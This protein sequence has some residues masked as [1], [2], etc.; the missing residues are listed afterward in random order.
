MVGPAGQTMRQ[1]L[2]GKRSMLFRLGTAEMTQ[3]VLP[4]ILSMHERSSMNLRTHQ[5][6]GTWNVQGMTAG[7]LEIVTKRM[8]EQHICVLGISK[9]WC[10]NQGRFTT[11]NGYTVIYSGK[12]EGKR[13]LVSSWTGIQ[14]DPSWASTQSATESSL[15]DC[16][17]TL[18]TYQLSRFMHQ[19]PLHLMKRW[20]TFMVSSKMSWIRFQAKIC[21][22]SWE[23]GTQKLARLTSNQGQLKVWIGRRNDRGDGLE[24]F[25]Q[26]ND[27][28]VETPSFSS[29]LQTVDLE[30]RRRK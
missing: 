9:T 3:S 19:H 17:V 10:L 22:S 8:G 23:T 24:E 5:V 6:I 14:L 18:S 7:K 28:I 2:L 13:E 12:D 11:D 30:E 20:K 29:P 4:T 15:S 1:W 16:M 26:E 27:L 21:L 25:C